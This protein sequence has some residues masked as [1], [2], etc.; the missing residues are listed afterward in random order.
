MPTVRYLGGRSMT[1]DPST[2][3]LSNARR[4]ERKDNPVLPFAV[5]L[6]IL[7][8]VLVITFAVRDQNP[9]PDAPA[10]PA[11]TANHSP[12][13]T[14]TATPTPGLVKE[15]SGWI[16]ATLVLPPTPTPTMPV[17]V[18][19]PTRA[20]RPTPSISQCAEYRWSSLQV[21][22]PMAQ[23][24]IDIRVNNRCPYDLGPANLW[25]D[26]TGWRDGGRVQSVRGHPFETIRRGRWGDLS[27]GLPGSLDWYDEIEVVVQD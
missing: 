13:P 25:F 2:T 18:P 20:P 24:K 11:P 10:A 12:S 14:P 19:H 7:T 4:P 27:I 23:V 3:R 17:F 1:E 8:I 21:F 22:S 26:I 5:V 9:T 6:V 16:D 15:S